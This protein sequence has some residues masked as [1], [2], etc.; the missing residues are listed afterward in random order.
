MARYY[1]KAKDLLL[2]ALFLLFII[3][4]VISMSHKSSN[5]TEARELA[6]MPALEFTRD[7]LRTYPSRFEAFF[8]DHFGLRGT[9]LK[10]NAVFTDKLFATSGS[11]KV[12]FGQH[13][14]LFFAAE[15]ELSDM[16]GQSPMSN[17]Q[18]QTWARYIK[19]RG[20][21]L[22]AQHI[23][24]RFVVSPEKHSIY[25]D[26]LPS[27]VQ[28]AGKP[29]ADAWRAAVNGSPYVVDLQ[30]GLQAQR[31]VAGD[32][33]YLH[34]DT[35]W[36]SWG[37]YTGYRQ[38]VQSLGG[39]Y[40]RHALQF[41]PADFSQRDAGRMR[42]LQRMAGRAGIEADYQP[43]LNKLP[44]CRE[45]PTGL[46]AL[47][48]EHADR[49]ALMSFITQSCPGG[50][51]TALVFRDSFVT[52][53][54][55]YLSQSFARITYVFGEPNDDLFVR[56]VQQE[57]PDVVIEERVERYLRVPLQA[58]LGPALQRLKDPQARGYTTAAFDAR[59][60]AYALLTRNGQLKQDSN[61]RYF[62]SAGQRWGNVVDTPI[63]DAGGR[64]QTASKFYRDYDGKF[65]GYQIGGWAVMQH[66]KVSADYVLVVADG[67]ASFVKPVD[68]VQADVA[69]RFDS[70][71][72]AQS[73]F[74]F[75]LPAT[76][77][78]KH[79]CDVQLYALHGRAAAAID[80]SALRKQMKVDRGD[81]CAPLAPQAGFY[82]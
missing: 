61:G 72:A 32:K 69:N 48:T 79:P 82:F 54:I 67:Y 18:L 77:L 44:A 52:A 35:H 46:L 37:A 5:T 21:W 26:F 68:Q 19:D 7:S 63:A 38:I 13:D 64:V 78:E 40:A 20:D 49:N 25:H 53:M 80:M 73:G 23:P 28:Y 34:T 16:L 17:D 36:T 2:A 74:S 39:D 9:L 24:Y 42:D 3:G 4:P 8:N 30:S 51:G 41:A 59:Q 45:V 47:G 71:G 31:A 10:V 62:E 76:L 55:P 11:S 66:D 58:Q 33:L 12:L 60:N 81:A 14:W 65:L 50:K 22:Q 57:H 15:D 27:N 56:M 29:R 6:G 70:A 43:D 1:L 75:V